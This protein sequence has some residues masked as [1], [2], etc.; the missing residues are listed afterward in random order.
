ML[1]ALI[2]LFGACT[3]EKTS[4]QKKIFSGNGCIERLTI[5]QNPHGIDAN[6][7]Q[8]VNGLFKINNIENSTLRY[9]GYRHDSL[10]TYYEPYALKDEKVVFVQ[11]YI[12]GLPLLTGDMSYVFL[13]DKFSGKG[14]ELT[15][16]TSLDN[17]PTLSLE[18]LRN[19]F[20]NSAQAFDGYGDKFKDTCLSAEFGYYNLNAGTSYAPETLVKAWRVV[21]KN[22]ERASQYPQACYQD[23]GTLLYYD[24]GIR[25]FK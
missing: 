10:Q 2:C 11:Q 20:L 18:D 5:P 17:K 16:G 3:K 21:I 25:T 14:G 12:N 22:S 6:E 8:T 4:V 9:Y 13:E 24:N 19:L 7:V 15:L 23:N 1:I